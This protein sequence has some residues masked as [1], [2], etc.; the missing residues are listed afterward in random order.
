MAQQVK[1]KKLEENFY[2]ESE[3]NEK[4]ANIHELNQKKFIKNQSKMLKSVTIK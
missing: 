3:K 4:L 1:D 2:R